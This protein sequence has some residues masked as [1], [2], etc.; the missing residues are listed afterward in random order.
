MQLELILRNS[1][2]FVPHYTLTGLPES[3]EAATF[4]KLIVGLPSF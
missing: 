1:F 4:Y 2:D 3:T